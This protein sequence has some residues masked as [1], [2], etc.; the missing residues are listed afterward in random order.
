MTN[1]VKS[2]DFFYR[3]PT[4]KDDAQWEEIIEKTE[5]FAPPEEIEGMEFVERVVLAKPQRKWC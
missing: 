5:T 3:T 1:T 4:E 2:G